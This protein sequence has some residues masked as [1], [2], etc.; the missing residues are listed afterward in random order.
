MNNSAATNHAQS[1]SACTRIAPASCTRRDMLRRMPLGFGAIALADLLQRDDPAYGKPAHANLASQQVGIAH[2]PSQVRSVVFMFLGGGPSQV[3]TFDPKPLLAKLA[4]KEVPESIAKDIPR[5]ARSP[6]H[7]LLP[8][9]WTFRQYG[10]CGLPVSDLFPTLAQHHIDDLCVIRS[11]R[12]D[13]PI[14]APAE[15]MT[16][17]GTQVGDRPS[18]GS[19]VTYGLGSDNDNLPSF[20]LF[21][22]GTTLRPP[23]FSAGFLPAR[24]QGV[25]VDLEQ[26]I[27]NIKL[28]GG[29]S[30]QQ[31]EAQLQFL[32]QLNQQHLQRLGETSELEARTKSYELSFRMQ[33]A[34]PE[35]F[36]L[37]QETRET[38][39]LY[40]AGE[41]H[42]DEYARIFMQARRLVERGVRFI[43]IRSGGWD[44]HS[45]IER[46]H[47]EKCRATDQP[48]AAF[49]TDLKRRGLLDQTLVI[50]SGEFG[51]TPSAEGKGEK[52]GRDHSPSGYSLWLAGGG[53]KGGQAIGATDPVGYAAIENPIHPND[54]HATILHAMGIDQYGLYYEQ[55]NRREIATVNGGRVVREAFQS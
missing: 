42:T 40:G 3:D 13:S 35:A 24:Y 34:A 7:N 32:R 36:D 52:A 38:Q 22:T 4:G 33:S 10:E 55:H 39:T 31:R 27:P 54:L 9:H 1:N 30:R 8:S 28:P 25:V 45:E 5:I 23:A 16:M 37:R 26:G 44:F 29:V 19:W 20:V 47:A 49:L 53:I 21:K 41:T 18:L 12:H 48:L 50:W 51:R 6:L 14:H 11:M 17:T 2:R 15:F 43:Q 46:K